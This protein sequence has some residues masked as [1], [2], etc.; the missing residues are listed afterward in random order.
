MGS[1]QE[2]QA[3]GFGLVVPSPTIILATA[4]GFV[5]ATGG[6]YLAGNLHGHKAENRI[7]TAKVAEQKAESGKV[8][9]GALQRLADQVNKDAEHSRQLESNYQAQLEALSAGSGDRERDLLGSLQRISGR[10]RSCDSAL[11]TE[12]NSPGGLTGDPSGGFNRL[13]RE[14]ARDLREVGDSANRLA[15]WAREVCYP[16]AL[17]HGR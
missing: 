16:F 4:L 15:T 7:W 9:A 5:L 1:A 8:L 13:L 2:R 12:A 11:T 17:E 14:T 3:G 6:A 10:W